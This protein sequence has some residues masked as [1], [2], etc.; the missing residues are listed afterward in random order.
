MVAL[1][2]EKTISILMYGTWNYFVG[3]IVHDTSRENW[4]KHAAH[5]KDVARHA[6]SSSL[7]FGVLMAGGSTS[8]HFF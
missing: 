6:S 1:Y 3:H 7:A 8:S 5:A 2:P 4:P